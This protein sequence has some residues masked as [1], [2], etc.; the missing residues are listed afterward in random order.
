V[1][2]VVRGLAQSEHDKDTVQLQPLLVSSQNSWARVDVTIEAPDF[3]EMDAPGPVPLAFAAVISNYRFGGTT[4]KVVVIGNASFAYDG[5][6]EAQ[7]N[8]DLWVNAITW[9]AGD[10]SVDNIAAKPIGASRLIIRGDDF[11]RL[12][13]IC[14]FVIPLVAFGSAIAMWALR[15]NR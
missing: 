8:G 11:V 4:A 3:T 14:L 10:R 1:L 9:L 12:S 2:P 13:I 5:N 15:R 6:I 7:A